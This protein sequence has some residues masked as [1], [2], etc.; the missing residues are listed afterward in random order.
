M[1]IATLIDTKT[2]E[3]TDYNLSDVTDMF[4]YLNA[5]AGYV[6]DDWALTDEDEES[7]DAANER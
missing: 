6:V 4:R 7:E 5:R 1:T 3:R 2:L